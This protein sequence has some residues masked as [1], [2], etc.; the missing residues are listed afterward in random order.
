VIKIHAMTEVRA[1]TIMATD[2]SANVLKDIKDTIVK[3]V[4]AI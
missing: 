1:L 4:N 3:R 2:T